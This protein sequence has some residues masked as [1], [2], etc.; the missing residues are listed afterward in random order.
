MS[1]APLGLWRPCSFFWALSSEAYR[2]AR[3]SSSR[4][5]PLPTCRDRNY[6]MSS[7]FLNIFFVSLDNN[8]GLPGIFEIYK[9]ALIY[10]MRRIP[11][12]IWCVTRLRF[13]CLLNRWNGYMIIF[14]LYPRLK[15]WALILQS[16]FTRNNKANKYI[17]AKCENSL[18]RFA[19]LSAWG[20]DRALQARTYN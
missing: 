14:V 16:N 10:P 8:S 7:S 1:T 18:P 19:G 5:I 11:L 2:S 3:V 13:S 12:Y 15:S 17:N 9:A 4:Y 20:T 6:S